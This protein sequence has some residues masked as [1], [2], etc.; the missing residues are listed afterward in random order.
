M[1]NATENTGIKSYYP[2]MGEAKPETL[3]EARLAHYGKHY[4]LTSQ[5]ELKGR[6][7]TFRGTLK[8]SQLTPQAQHKVGYHEYKVTIAAF[9]KICKQYAVGY[10][11]PLD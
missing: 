6:G 11:M 4:F 2:E 3:I 1:T 7:V 9:D 10:E 8:A 5:V